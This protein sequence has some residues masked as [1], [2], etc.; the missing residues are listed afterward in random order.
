MAGIACPALRLANGLEYPLLGFGTWGLRGGALQTALGVVFSK[1][2]AEQHRLLD[3]SSGYRNEDEI[4]HVLSTIEGAERIM[5]QS[6]IGPRSM[7]SKRARQAAAA[8][9]RSMGRLDVLLIHWPGNDRRQRFET[10]KALEDLYSEGAVRAIGVS[11]FLPEHIRELMEDGAQM[12]PM[13]NQFELHPLCQS[14][15]IVEY[16]RDEGIAV[17]SYSTL[18]GG[19]RQGKIRLEDGTAILLGHPTVRMIADEI[20]LSPALVC[21]RWAMQQGFSTLHRS[22]CP[23]HIAENAAVL[24]FQLSEQQMAQL[25]ALDDDHHFAWDPRTIS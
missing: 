2:R 1:Q 20:H 9:V 14:R 12:K 8:S 11:N 10:W 6:K 17:Q 25:M 7:G 4:G 13:I 3:T 16:C 19:P 22:K 23:S 15:G 21:L 18:G 5:I 24:D